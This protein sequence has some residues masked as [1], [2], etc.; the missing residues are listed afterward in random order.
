MYLRSIILHSAEMVLLSMKLK[1]VQLSL[2]TLSLILLLISTVRISPVVAERMMWI[3]N[4]KSIYHHH[5]RH[6]EC[7]QRCTYSDY[8]AEM[9]DEDIKSSSNGWKHSICKNMHIDWF[10]FFSFLVRL[11]VYRTEWL[12][13]IIIMATPIVKLIIYE[14]IEHK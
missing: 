6:Y 1:S 7:V 10:K 11:Q 8:I 4:I 3:S 12:D 13:F 5:H 9:E 2:V 14:M